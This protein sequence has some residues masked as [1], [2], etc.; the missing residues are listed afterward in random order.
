MQLIW[1]S[2]GR[3]GVSQYGRVATNSG[4]LR[5]PEYEYEKEEGEKKKE[6]KITI[7]VMTVLTII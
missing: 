4:L 5:P 7:I 2:I 3:V 6:K 1:S